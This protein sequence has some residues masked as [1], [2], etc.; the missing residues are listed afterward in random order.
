MDSLFASVLGT[1]ESAMT[2]MT[3]TGFFMCTLS[4][5]VLGLLCAL[6]YMYKHKIGRAHV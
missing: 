1:T 6:I 3:S 5:L 4:S 2:T